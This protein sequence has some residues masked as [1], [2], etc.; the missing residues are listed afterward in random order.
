MVK[1]CNH[2]FQHVEFSDGRLVH[3]ATE[4]NL[5]IV[6]LKSIRVQLN[7]LTFMKRII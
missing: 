3:G 4:L 1:Y 7:H 2:F 5:Q 6:L